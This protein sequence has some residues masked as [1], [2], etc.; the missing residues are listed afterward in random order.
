M[1][2]CSACFDL[3]A[4]YSRFSPSYPIWQINAEERLLQQAAVKCRDHQK[5]SESLFNT[6]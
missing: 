1:R 4:D 6:E 5:P 2:L 3:L